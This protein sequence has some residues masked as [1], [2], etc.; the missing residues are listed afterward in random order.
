MTYG[1][2]ERVRVEHSAESVRRV[3]LVTHG[4]HRNGGVGT[5][6]SWLRD[7]LRASGRFT[8]DL[9]DLATSAGDRSSRRLRAPRS[10]WR[11]SV[12]SGRADAP[13]E[14][15]WGANAVELEFMRYRPRRELTAALA[16]YDLIQVVCGSPAWAAPVLAA[17]P[18]VVVQMA[19]LARW[20]RDSHPKSCGYA[21]AGWRA[22][23]TR[24]TDR[25]E[26]STLHAVDAVLVE[27]QPIFNWIEALGQ[28]NVVLAPPG[29]DTDRFSPSPA[30]WRSDGYLLS[31]CRLAEPRKGLDRMVRGYAEILRTRPDAPPLVL[32]GKGRLEPSVAALI[33]ELGLTHRIVVRPDVSAGDLPELYRGASVFLQTSYE[34]GLG[35]SVIEAMA[36]GV[37]AVATATYGSRESV[38]DGRTGWLVPLEPAAEVSQFLAAR[39]LDVLDQSGPGMAAA[40]RHRCEQAFSQQVALGRFVETYDRLLGAGGARR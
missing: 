31:V 6:V 1:I 3:A 15:Y 29:V 16:D 13:D 11:R 37:P 32:A 22:A 23:M 20:E 4:L 24:I 40:A 38:V 7:G 25:I 2:S 9:H 17:G 34:E 10:W 35:M 5:V 14:R 21:L 18:P 19:T 30:G 36:C 8:V 27:N 28:P 39:V 33:A 12:L 26:R